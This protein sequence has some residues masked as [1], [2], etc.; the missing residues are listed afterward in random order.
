MCV[1]VCVCEEISGKSIN[2]NT[3]KGFYNDISSLFKKYF[4]RSS[5]FRK[6]K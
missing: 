1:C 3:D 5:Y 2:L 4:I 6:N